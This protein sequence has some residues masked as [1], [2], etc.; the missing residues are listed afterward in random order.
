VFAGVS[1]AALTPPLSPG[2]VHVWHFNRQTVAGELEWL[3]SLLSSDE[4]QRAR[5]FHYA[6]DRDLF[7]TARGLLRSVAAGYLGVAPGAVQFRYSAKGKPE[8]DGR[9]PAS[10]L[11]FNV[12]HSGDLVVLAFA[13]K[14]RV[15]V[16]V[17]QIQADALLATVAQRFFSPAEVALL[18]S[19]PAP[20]RLQMFY[21]CKESAL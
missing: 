20:E 10:E 1:A 18:R 12:S 6:N 7:V 21:R 15:G 4:Q 13:H 2:E 11:Y 8:L 17:E 16:D 3:K 5:R 9:H 14:R 19:L